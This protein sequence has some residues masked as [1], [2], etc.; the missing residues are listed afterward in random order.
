MMKEQFSAKSI[1]FIISFV[2]GCLLN[3]TCNYIE[4]ERCK[5]DNSVCKFVIYVITYPC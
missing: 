5:D 3:N 1:G 4:F 2:P